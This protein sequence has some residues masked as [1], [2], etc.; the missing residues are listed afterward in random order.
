MTKK[1]GIFKGLKDFGKNNTRVALAVFW[2]SIAPSVFS[3]LLIPTIVSKSAN[4][5]DLNISA[6]PE[7]LIFVIV[8]TLMMGLALTPTTL[9]AIL[10]GFIFGWQTFPLLI[11]SYTFATLLGYGWGKR[12]GGDSLEE[13]LTQYPKAAVMIESKKDSVGAL[14]FFVR[15]S[16][17]IP[18]ALSNL[19]FALMKTGW[20]KLVIWGTIGMLPRTTL[21]FFSGTLAFDIYSAIGQESISGK[22]WIFL[23]LLLLSIWGIWR[24]FRK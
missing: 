17:V 2:V 19:L 5:Y 21:A 6:F 10:S 15:I 22:W 8:G 9:F 18:F 23:G 24:F 4:P 3:L 13:L 12:L 16:P 20:K 11:L 14:I 7:S 1:V